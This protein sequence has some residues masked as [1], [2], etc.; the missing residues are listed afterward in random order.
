MLG[1]RVA[2]SS[3]HLDLA[4][5]TIPVG[6]RRTARRHWLASAGAV[7]VRGAVVAR[8]ASVRS[9]VA[10]AVVTRPAALRRVERDDGGPALT[11]K[12]VPIML[13]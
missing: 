6:G 4:G 10:R 12:R 11:G 5:T 1:L 2:Q 3:G 8:A 9:V 7:V 13:F